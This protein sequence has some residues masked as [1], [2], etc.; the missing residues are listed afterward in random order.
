MLLI[1]IMQPKINLEITDNKKKI[2]LQL[3]LY[4]EIWKSFLRNYG[5]LAVFLGSTIEGAYFDDSR[6]FCIHWYLRFKKW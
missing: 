3:I 5:Y 6:V 4:R 1:K 2:L